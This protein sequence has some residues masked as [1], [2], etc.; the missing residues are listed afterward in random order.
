MLTNSGT[1]ALAITSITASGDFTATNN[2][3]SSVAT[4][5]NCTISVTF[6][7][8]ASGT[9]TGAVTITDNA[10]G[11]PQAIALTG[12]G[13]APVIAATLSSTSLTFAAQ[14]TGS[15][16]AA[17]TVMLTNTGTG[18]LA[19]SSIAASANFGETNTCGSS[20][21]AGGNCTISVT[22]TPT[23]A[24]SLAGTVTVTDN[25]SSSPQTVALAGTGTSV[26]VVPTT[27]SLSI[28]SPGGSATD[29]IQITSAGGFSGTVNL[30]CTVTYQGTATPTDL[31]TCSLNP[32]Q[33]QVTAGSPLSSTLTVS[34]TGTGSQAR[35][36]GAWLPSG[37]ALAALFF[38]GF[39]PRRRGKNTMLFV[40]L[41]MTLGCAATGCGGSSQEQTTTGSY[42]V[43]VKATSATVTASTTIALALQ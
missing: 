5:A 19:I 39:L 7:P 3:S 23:A 40:L 9:R 43:V 33:G 28:P 38:I 26:G 6:T 41:A 11:S 17:Q 32:Q 1:G 37:T 18:V 35:S 4:G 10:A 13:I 12:T 29:T 27:G 21:A 2:C 16:S 14:A 30:T 25:T 20:L 42:Q 34:T 24:G 8:T 36:N 22:F 31:P 15:T